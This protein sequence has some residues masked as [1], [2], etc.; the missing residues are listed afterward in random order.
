MNKIFYFLITLNTVN[1]AFAS[2]GATRESDKK[3]L[4]LGLS[5]LENITP[6]KYEI[7]YYQNIL[8][9]LGQVY[10]DSEENKKDYYLIKHSCSMIFF[11]HFY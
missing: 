6:D 11:T 10:E 5:K 8:F 9:Q 3:E 7:L 2:D 1:Y 4:N